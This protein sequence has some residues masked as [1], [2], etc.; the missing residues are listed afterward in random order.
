MKRL[1]VLLAV[2]LVPSLAYANTGIFDGSGQTIKLVHSEE[3][4]L[5]SESV[6][7]VPSRGPLPFNGSSTDRVEYSCKFVLRNRTK[8]PVKIQV[9]FPLNS[10]FTG[11]GTKLKT[12]DATDLVL[13]YKFI[14][15]DRDHTYHVRFVPYGQ[16]KTLESIFLWNMT[17]Q[18]T[19]VREL[20]VAYEIPMAMGAGTNAKDWKATNPKEWYD[21]LEPTIYEGFEYVT[22]TGRSWAGPIEHATFEIDVRGFE[23]YLGERSIIETEA[24]ELTAEERK[25]WEA[26]AAAAVAAMS[27]AERLYWQQ[28]RQA[29]WSVKHREIRR[30]VK[31]DGWKDQVKFDGWKGKEGVL[32]WDFKNYRP[33]DPIVINY[34]LTL[35]PKKAEDVPSF[36][37]WMIGKRPSAEDLGDLRE[38]YLAWWGIVP[39]SDSV[40]KFVSNQI[41]YAP[42]SGMTIE[43]LTAEQRTVVSALERYPAAGKAT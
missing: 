21:N 34:Y 7:I 30:E 36:V 10:E 3:I 39:K 41:W 31:P 23:H 14:A 28:H 5:Q 33:K 15:R 29:D 8:K 11:R 22:E 17:F 19:E 4:Q 35:F 18:S 20:S 32:T 2:A 13:H 24:P 40:R 9:G 1:F 27:E 6:R 26:A 25:A 42:K 12:D 37:K 38:I 43:K 16:E